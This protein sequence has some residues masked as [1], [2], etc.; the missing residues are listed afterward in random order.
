MLK[1]TSIKV[2]F[3]AI[4]MMLLGNNAFCA[5]EDLAQEIRQKEEI[6]NTLKNEIAQID[7]EMIRCE[8]TKKGWVAATVVGG[9]GVVSTGVAA[10]VQGA[11]IHDQKQDINRQNQRLNELNSQK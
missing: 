5:D 8:K 1:N 2:L 10:G 4:P 3:L 11:K 7:S 6:L 9:V